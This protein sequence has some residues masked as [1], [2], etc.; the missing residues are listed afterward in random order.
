MTGNI[1]F[2]MKIDR[3]IFFIKNFQKYKKFQKNIFPSER[4]LDLEEKEVLIK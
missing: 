2:S 4:R 1:Y 3:L